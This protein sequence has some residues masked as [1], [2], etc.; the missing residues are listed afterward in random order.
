MADSK[1]VEPFIDMSDD[2]GTRLF[3]L[4]PAGHEFRIKPKLLQYRAPTF[5]QEALKQ[6]YEYEAAHEQGPTYDL[7]ENNLSNGA[8]LER[9]F[10]YNVSFDIFTGFIAWLK[11][12]TLVHMINSAPRHEDPIPK[13]YN[14]V[15]LYCFAQRFQITTLQ[16]LTMTSIHR[17]HAHWIALPTVQMM[18]YTD[19]HTTRACG[20]R[21]FMARSLAYNYEIGAIMEYQGCAQTVAYCWRLHADS[22]KHSAQHNNTL[23]GGVPQMPWC[24]VENEKGS[25]YPL[26]DYMCRSFEREER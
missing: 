22:W 17:V 11:T 5:L 7:L 3:V 24:E 16:D 10:V 25:G 4:M 26:E 21:L 13:L 2:I 15:E 14:S 18:A 20:L 8:A 19:T 9:I 6:Q 23:L 1:A 12:N